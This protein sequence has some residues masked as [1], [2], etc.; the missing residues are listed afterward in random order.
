MNNKLQRI[1][2][3]GLDLEFE[4][5]NVLYSPVCL[6]PIHAAQHSCR[7]DLGAIVQCWSGALPGLES[8]VRECKIL[9]CAE[10]LDNRRDAWKERTPGKKYRTQI[11]K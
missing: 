1:E 6:V 10:S 8:F 11:L 9:K 7:I 2:L 4:Y 3:F 5:Y